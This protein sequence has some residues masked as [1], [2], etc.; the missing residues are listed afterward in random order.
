MH[1]AE[2]LRAAPAPVCLQLCPCQAKKRGE[3]RQDGYQSS[4][5]QALLLHLS[6]ERRLFYQNPCV[7][8]PWLLWA[9]RAASPKQVLC[10][11]SGCCV[12]WWVLDQNH[13]VAAQDSLCL[14]LQHSQGAR[15]GWEPMA[16]NTQDRHLGA[17][18]SALSACLF[19]INTLYKYTFPL[20]TFS[21][22]APRAELQTD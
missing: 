18:A 17:A 2:L 13:H 11:P 20:A 19:K 10:L 22:P 7:L 12:S 1:P 8:W 16:R 4:L 6:S 3:K 21:G 5:S 14:W 9:A 15:S